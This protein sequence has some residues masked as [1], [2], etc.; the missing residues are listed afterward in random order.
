LCQ[1]L[2]LGRAARGLAVVFVFR[3]PSALGLPGVLKL[4]LFGQF[5]V[6]RLSFADRDLL[7]SR[8]LAWIRLSPLTRAS[9]NPDDARR[10]LPWDLFSIAD[11][12]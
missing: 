10:P 1:A 5:V 7:V 2:T 6:T 4:R 3:W 11:P 12:T 9:R 8:S